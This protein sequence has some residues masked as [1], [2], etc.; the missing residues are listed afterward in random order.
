MKTPQGF[1][2]AGVH[3]GIKAVRRDLALFESEAPCAVAGLFTVNRARAWPI[4]DA[5]ARVPGAG[6]RALIVNSGNANALTGEQGKRD[7]GALHAAWARSLGVEPSAVLS[8]STGVIGVRLPV[9]KLSQA[10]LAENRRTTIEGAAEA[11]LTTDTRPKL[12]G[13]T[14][15]KATIAA[16]AKGSGMVAP[17]LATMLAVITTDAEIAPAEL[18]AILARVVDQTFLDLVIDGEM[19]TNDAV[20]AMANGLAGPVDPGEFEAALVEVCR[21]LA[22]MIAEDGEGATKTITVR[23]DGA[24]DRASARD[25]ARAIAGSTLVKAAVFGADP[26][27]GRVLATVGARTAT[28]G[29]PFDP[30][31]ARLVLQGVTVFSQGEPAAI[32]AAQLRKQLRRP[33]VSIDVT[34]GEGPG[35]GEALGCDLSYDYIK[36]NADYAATIQA[37]P[38]GVVA[39]DDRLA[40][41]TPALKRAIV[42]EALSYIADFSGKRAVVCVRGE[43]LVKDSLRASF[44]SDINLLDAAGLQPIVVHESGT[45]GELVALLNQESAR[46]VGISGKDGG[47]LR[48]KKGEIPRADPELLELLLS[49][50]YVP[51][52]APIALGDDGEPHALETHAAAA[53]LALVAKAEK[54]IYLADA[55]GIMQGGELLSELTAA[56]LRAKIE[57]GVVSGDALAESV[58]VALDGGIPRVHVVDGRMP[59]GVVAELFTDRGVGTLVTR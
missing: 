54:L 41:Y 47:L 26:N 13:R 36:I 31:Q 53:A 59:H 39:R 20:F 50:G 12:A 46:A 48:A 35:S 15:G 7:V 10:K 28:R 18:Q 51:V 58:L 19:S 27:W 42:V 57:S 4:E 6:F 2:Y 25:V 1:R 55:P 3:A 11:I 52:I 49:R 23:V 29:I 45:S 30:R 22:R 9:E 5:A 34:I 44:A 17:S 21:E 56:E 37:S 32:D 24:P 33:E 40:S 16:C 14:V 8:A 43:S 38:E